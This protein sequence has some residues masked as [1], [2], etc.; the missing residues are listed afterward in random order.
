MREGGWVDTVYIYG[1]RDM[2]DRGNVEIFKHN[3]PTRSLHHYD[4]F[5]IM[6][7]ASL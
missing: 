2:C 7:A 3:H 5:I 6:I 1:E 4:C